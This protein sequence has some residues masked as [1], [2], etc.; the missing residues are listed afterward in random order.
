MAL[1]IAYLNE[2]PGLKHHRLGSIVSGRIQWN[3]ISEWF[4]N[5]PSKICFNAI[6][7]DTQ[8]FSFSTKEIQSIDIIIL[9]VTYD[10]M[11]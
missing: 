4:V 6:T 10:C 9:I 3:W 1:E 2:I 7:A 11:L 8:Y 5:G